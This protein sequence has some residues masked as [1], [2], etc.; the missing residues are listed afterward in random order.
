MAATGVDLVPTFAVLRLMA[1]QWR[2]WGVPE[3]ALPKLAGA[4]EAMAAS[5]KLAVAAGVRIGSGSDILGPK[6]EHRGLELV[7]KSELLGPMAA[8]TSATSANAGILRVAER[9]GRVAEDMVADVIAVAGD[10]LGE[11]GVLDDPRRVVLVV[12]G[13][14]VVKDQR[15]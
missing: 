4:E 2:E 1:A 12:K 13:G 3:E 15:A 14:Q 7:I 6:Q 5:M 10:P 9:V 11:P 8:I